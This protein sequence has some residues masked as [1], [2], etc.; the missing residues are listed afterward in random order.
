[1]ANS[2]T[3]RDGQQARPEGDNTEKSAA[4]TSL[5]GSPEAVSLPSLVPVHGGLLPPPLGE[6]YRIKHRL[7]HGTGEADVW[8]SHDQITT[9]D[10][11]VKLYHHKV[12]PKSDVLERVKS[13][14]TEHVVDLLD[15]GR[16]ADAD[17]KW[18]EVLEYAPHGSLETMMVG[19]VEPSLIR[20]ALTE[21]HIAL[22]YF[23]GND[24]F[25]RDLKPANILV[26]SLDPLDLVLADFGIARPVDGLPVTRLH[27][28]W[29]YASPECLQ[30]QIG[31]Q[32]DYWA[33]GMMVYE[34]LTGAHPW[35]GLGET[36]IMQ[37]L[38]NS[39]FGFIAD[40]Q[41][42][43]WRS[44]CAGLLQRLPN[45]RWGAEQ[46]GLWLEGKCPPVPQ[47]SAD[48]PSPRAFTIEG[49]DCTSLSQLAFLLAKYW[50]VGVQHFGRGKV[51]E[52][53]RKELRHEEIATFVSMLMDEDRLDINERLFRFLVHVA[54]TQPRVYKHISLS[55]PTLHALANDA[56]KGDTKAR[57]AIRELR[58]RNILELVTQGE[59]VQVGRDWASAVALF[60]ASP[61]A[62]RNH[63][64]DQVLASLLRIVTD[65]C[66]DLSQPIT[67]ADLKLLMPA[68][69]SGPPSRPNAGYEVYQ[70]NPFDSI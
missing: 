15:Y 25:H 23:H 36:T 45:H 17:K 22:W 55:R 24:L 21:I 3:R 68:S 13:L 60:H 57:Q 58:D 56:L 67:E 64:D 52:W 34:W 5:D 28:T 69:S 6:R 70:G 18:Y 19:A 35:K 37:R 39:E 31:P 14:G 42:P 20:A 66:R 10:V 4:K 26:R 9:H 63:P 51:L 12:E 27:A 40:V 48:A 54:P 33:L 7:A 53:V 2:P 32:V 29:M 44:L 46:I 61:R 47:P 41:D 59:L 16:T 8:L 65:E 49:E 1:M 62:G 50:D 30:A 38:A 43:E 11:V